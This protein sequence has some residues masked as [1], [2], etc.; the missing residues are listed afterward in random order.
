[1]EV[2]RLHLEEEGYCNFVALDDSR[3]ALDTAR[4]EQPDIL[5]LDLMMPHVSGFE[6]LEQLRAD[7]DLQQIPVIV[8]TS[9]DTA[10]TKLRALTLG[11]NDF[12]SK[13]VDSSE[14]ALRLRNTLSAQAYQHRLTH[15][16]NL[17]GLPNRR[18]L[19]RDWV[20]LDRDCARTGTSAALLLINLD[21]FKVINDSFG[22]G[23]GDSL[24]RQFAL[25]LQSQFERD[26]SVRR[27]DGVSSGKLYRVGGDKFIL[28]LPELDGRQS[29]VT[30]VSQLMRM[31]DE[32]FEHAGQEIYISCSVGIASLP[33]DGLDEEA[34]ISKAETAMVHAKSHRHNSYSY[35]STDM[36]EQAREMLGIE[37]GLRS[38]LE[39][40]EFYIVYQPKV[41]V[42]SG[43]IVAAEAL[44]RWEHPTFG[45]VSP[46]HFIPLAEDSGMI[47][48]IGQWVLR[49]ACHQARL[50][51]ELGF[52]HFRIAVNVSIRQL[53]EEAFI[54]CI[55]AT[56]NECKL[57]PGA[58]NIELTEN[59]IMENARS[60]VEKLLELKKIGVRISVDDFGTGYSSLSYLQK[61]PLDELKVDKS[62]VETITDAG[63]RAPIVNAVISLAHDL[64]MSVVA[65]GVEEDYQLEYI[66]KLDCEEYQG[67][68]CSKP[69]K[70]SDFENLLLSQSKKAA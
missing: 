43:Q 11:A 64:G 27:T 28:M 52:P 44:V 56:L 36:D 32:P 1:M 41:C 69:L 37:N 3:Y 57:D 66:R 25:R 15:F 63:G 58:L 50:W 46:E 48:S 60:N 31:M 68:L 65:E 55:K 29:V 17:T 8:L 35:Y 54:S 24:M 70:W 39:N 21:R 19:G 33:D 4:R 62:F 7:V 2:L 42:K 26:D 45:I 40:D 5:L 34:L 18:S 20:S 22:R 23:G 61:F 49:Q 12:L 14:L 10:E 67:Y 53:Y 47:V 30:V 38:A 13:P 9:S 16:D 6:I 59:M 51:R